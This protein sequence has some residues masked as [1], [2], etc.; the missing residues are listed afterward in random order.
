M[1]SGRL[2]R[3]RAH[4]SAHASWHDTHDSACVSTQSD[5]HS[6][7][8]PHHPTEAQ[9]TNSQWPSDRLDAVSLSPPAS[10]IARVPRS[11]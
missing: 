4:L 2:G 3:G 9:A 10:C 6:T 8:P 1:R 7:T 5:L 11:P